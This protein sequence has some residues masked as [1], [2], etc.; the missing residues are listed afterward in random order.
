MI[1]FQSYACMQFAC[2]G[3]EGAGMGA[4]YSLM[5]RNLFFLNYFRQCFE[6]QKKIFVLCIIMGLTEGTGHLFYDGRLF[7]MFII[8]IC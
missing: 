4:T 3:E 8:L 7:L 5:D 2:R 6:M 1:H